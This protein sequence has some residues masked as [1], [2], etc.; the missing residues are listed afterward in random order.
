M[1]SGEPVVTPTLAQALAQLESILEREAINCQRPVV[2]SQESKS[3]QEGISNGLWRA[4]GI[5]ERWRQT[6]CPNG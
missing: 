5:V 3:F 2:T 4:R 6:W 1:S